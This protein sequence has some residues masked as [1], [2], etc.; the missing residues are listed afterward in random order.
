MAQY[1]STRLFPK[2]M[3]PMVHGADSKP[4]L[5]LALM[6]S[7]P[8]HV[9]LVGIVGISEDESLS[10]AALPA[11]Q[12]RQR[13]RQAAGRRPVRVVQRIRASHRPWREVAR[14]AREEQPDLLVLGVSELA[15]LNTTLAE[16]LHNPPCDMIVVGGALPERPGRVVCALRGG[17]YAEL[18]LRLALAIGR[19]SRAKI[20]ALHVTPKGAEPPDEAAFKGVDQVLRNLPQVRRKHL[21]TNDPAQTILK[22]AR[23]SDLLVIGASARPADAQVSIGVVAEEILRHRTRGIL[24]V[25]SSR[26][27]PPDMESEA[28]GQ[29]AISV[30]VDRWFAENTYHAEE[31]ADL[32][33]LLAAK[34][35]Q[36]LTVSLALPALNE[37][38]TV[39][40]VIRTIRDALVQRVALVD[41]M[42]LIDSASTDRTRQIARSLN[43]PVYVHQEILPD[44]GARTGKGEAL[45]KS[46]YLTHGDILIWTDTDIV[47]IHP[48]FVYGLLGALI[49]HPEIQFVKGFYRR[50]LKVG[51]RQHAGGGGRVTELTARPLLNLFFP[52]LSGIIQPLSGEYG[53]RRTALEQMAFSSGYGVEIGLLI[54]VFER[55]GLGSIAQVDLQ[56]RIHHN[57]PL[58]SLS[59]MSF[60]IIQTVIRRIERRYGIQLLED[61]N[62]TMK[63]IRYGQRRL[64]LDVQQIAELE[65][66]PMIQIGDYGKGSSV[67]E[68]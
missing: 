21:E 2:V 62:K 17:P 51:N 60:A 13:M 56:E 28:A 1:Y 63:L 44:L 64:L 37:Q 41:E 33:Q 19:T 11:R 22:T 9:T 30:L 27:L 57:Q 25:K 47:N 66:P 31:F 4:A 5:G 23:G 16:A 34:R 58:E 52:A 43:I 10:A 54:D 59:K 20:T 50:P 14:A 35:A 15:C 18:T 61:V 45:W 40:H 32:H 26:P 53:G 55:F 7:E 48:R 46:L 3:V 39:G 29:T 49:M 67:R 24:I 42:V 38:Q 12:V 36:G 68:E 8:A 65:R 6:I